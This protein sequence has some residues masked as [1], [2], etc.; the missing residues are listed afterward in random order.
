MNPHNIVRDL[1]IEPTSKIILVVADGLGG[2]ALEPGGKTELE[3]ARKPHLDALARQGACG[4]VI[5]LL[6]GVTPGGV[7]GLLSLFGYDP[8]EYG[9]GRGSTNSVGKSAEVP[10][11]HDVYGVRAALFT[12]DSA[13]VALA[14]L[15]G[16]DVHEVGDV[17]DQVASMRRSWSQYDLFVMHHADADRAGVAGNFDAKVKAIERLDAVVPQLLSL[18]PDVLS[19]TGGRSTPAKLHSPSWHPVPVVIW[20]KTC[21]TDAVKEFGETACSAGGLGHFPAAQLMT[22]LL[23]HAQR[24]RPYGN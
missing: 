15:L 1:R 5:S 14:R 20:A 21:R 9:I 23:A 22:L 10:R 8:L 24:L 6:P 16:V 12:E 13:C 7:S 4:L 11:V 18:S 2:M 19:V 17:T 3:T